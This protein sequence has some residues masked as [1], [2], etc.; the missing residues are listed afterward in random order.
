MNAIF[1][2]RLRNAIIWTTATLGVSFILSLIAS[3]FEVGHSTNIQDLND[4]IWWWLSSVTG[5]NFIF[6]VPVTI[7]GK[8]FTS[9]VGLSDLFLLAIVISEVTA[10]IKLLYV[11]KERGIIRIKS[12]GHVVIYGYTSLTAGVVK[13]LRRHFG[14]KLKIVLVSNEIIKNPFPSQVD[15]IFA[16]PITRA[17]FKEAN[18]KYATAAIILAN[19]RFTDPDAYSLVIASGIEKDNSRVVTLIEIMDPEMKGLFKE[20]NIDAFIDRRELLKDLLERNEKPKLIR[21]INKQTDLDDRIEE[22][23]KVDL[24]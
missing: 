6:I 22:D 15:F 14:T 3:I 12:T 18:I 4:V 11:H 17:T 8:I 20:S 21:I 2:S 24:I 1:R 19:D 7:G 23:E 5:A 10:L 16:N 9:L 13:L